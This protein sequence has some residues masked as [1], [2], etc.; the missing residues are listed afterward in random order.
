[1]GATLRQEDGE[2][3]QKANTAASLLGKERGQTT[4]LLFAGSVQ[5][6]PLSLSSVFSYS[7]EYE[8]VPTCPVFLIT[9]SQLALKK[10]KSEEVIY[11]VEQTMGLSEQWS[12]CQGIGSAAKEG[13]V[14]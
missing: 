14:R 6:C 12:G 4:E 10:K 1:M 11:S 9:I 3:D 5:C 13:T 2:V 8:R 7:V